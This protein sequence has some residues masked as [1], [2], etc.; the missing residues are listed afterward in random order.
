M[1]SIRKKRNS[2]YWFA[3]FTQI[4]GSRVQRSTKETDRK[5]A[6]TLADN[7]EQAARRQV[8]AR[9]AQRVMAEIFQ[10]VSGEPLPSTSIRSYFESWLAR[11]KP[12][13]AGITYIF[14]SG[15]ARRCLDW[16]GERAAREL[17]RITSGDML[18]FRTSEAARVSPPTVN[19]AIKFLRMV[20]ED[21]KRDGIIPDNPADTVRLMKRTGERSRRPFTVSEIKR[22]LAIAGDEWRSLIVLACTPASGWAISRG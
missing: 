11:K 18:A 7:F 22:L 17:F 8:T 10:R 12:E 9:Q 13:T 21:A 6:Q 19:H 4:D 2:K 14:Y 1:G 3:C 16:L 15:K 20:F 5:R